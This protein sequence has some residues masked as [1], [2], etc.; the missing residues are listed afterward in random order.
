MYICMY[1]MYVC[2]YVHI[3]QLQPLPRLTVEC[4]ISFRFGTL[5]LSISTEAEKSFQ[6]INL[7][8]T[9]HSGSWS[10]NCI[11][12]RGRTSLSRLQ[13]GQLGL[14]PLRLVEPA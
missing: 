1:V 8:Y 13:T 11:L 3:H 9:L 12:K 14:G 6:F 5:T 4:Y 2:M 7:C 10:C